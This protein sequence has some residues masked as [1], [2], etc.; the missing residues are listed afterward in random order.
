MLSIRV[1]EHKP[2]DISL[3]NFKR[4]CE[5]AGIKQEL[6]DRQH[7][8]KPTEKRKIAK[9]QAVK[10]ARISQRRAFI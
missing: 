2:F 5:K 1:D 9:R 10:R 4:A 6:R 7:Y 8:V 3:R